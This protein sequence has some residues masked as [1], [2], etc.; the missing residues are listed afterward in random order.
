MS[1]VQNIVEVQ[2]IPKWQD[3]LKTNEA[4]VA[5]I[6]E[7]SSK[8]DDLKIAL[9]NAIQ[10][11]NAQL[12]DFLDRD[13]MDRGRV[14]ASEW[15][16]EAQAMQQVAGEINQVFNR[17]MQTEI[18]TSDEL[19]QTLGKMDLS[20]VDNL[21]P[22]ELAQMFMTQEEIKKAEINQS[23]ERTINL[24][25]NLFVVKKV[26]DLAKEKAEKAKG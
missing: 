16:E 17:F 5:E 26:E 6:L 14:D 20:N 1:E 18:M 24:A 8:P 3:L 13:L 2:S 11:L 15:T 4:L 9:D 23:A 7:R 21:S 22:V 12:D 19:I 25:R 10:R